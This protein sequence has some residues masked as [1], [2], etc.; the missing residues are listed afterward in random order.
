MDGIALDPIHVENLK[1][2]QLELFVG[3]ANFDGRTIPDSATK[4]LT[5]KDM[6]ENEH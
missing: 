3:L 4:M 5:L 6:T 1:N 2:Q